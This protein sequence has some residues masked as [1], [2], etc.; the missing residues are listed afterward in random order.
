MRAASTLQ[1]DRSIRPRSIVAA[2]PHQVPAHLKPSSPQPGSCTQTWQVL[3]SQ[4]VAARVA[5]IRY[6]LTATNTG[7]AAVAWPPQ[8]LFAPLPAGLCRLLGRLQAR[9]ADLDA[10]A[11]G[12]DQVGLRDAA[13]RLGVLFRRR[14]GQQLKDL[15]TSRVEGLHHRDW[16]H[17]AGRITTPEC[18]LPLLLL[19]SM[20]SP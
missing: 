8:A 11:A 13:H 2:Q 1:R 10:A 16:H 3:A 15:C 19:I 17:S 20:A 5:G 18:V 9:H 4:Q 6:S 12:G 7:V 14:P